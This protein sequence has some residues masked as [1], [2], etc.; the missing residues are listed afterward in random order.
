MILA[1]IGQ[2][3][4]DTTCFHHDANRQIRDKLACS[5]TRESLKLTS[6]VHKLWSRGLVF[7]KSSLAFLS[8]IVA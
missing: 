8:Y 3:H 6:M 4:Y 5:L 7:M 1:D 2:T